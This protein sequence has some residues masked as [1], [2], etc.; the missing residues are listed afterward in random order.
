MERRVKS[1]KISRSFLLLTVCV[2]RSVDFFSGAAI[3]AIKAPFC[4]GMAIR[5]SVDLVPAY[6]TIGGSAPFADI[7]YFTRLSV[8]LVSHI[9]NLK[10]REIGFLKVSYFS[11]QF[12]QNFSSLH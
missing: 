4:V 6:I 7:A 8:V 9:T 3:I 1:L 10:P 5:N 2:E 12:T 11:I